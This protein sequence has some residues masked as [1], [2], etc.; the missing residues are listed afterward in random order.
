MRARSRYRSIGADVFQT[1]AAPSCPAGQ[2]YEPDTS[3]TTIKGMGKCVPNVV[4]VKPLTLH[5][6]P[7]PAPAPQPA[8]VVVAPLTFQTPAPSQPTGGDFAPAP[9]PVVVASCPPVWPW[10]WLLVAFGV[11]AGGAYYIQKNQKKAKKNIGRVANEFGGRIVNGA[12]NAALSRLF[13]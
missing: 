3:S 10:W 4:T 11:G 2:H 12:S 8:P 7:A 1:Q 6:A 9:A 13:G 5:L